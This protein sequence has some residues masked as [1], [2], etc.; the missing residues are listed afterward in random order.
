VQ[1]PQLRT[2]LCYLHSAY[3]GTNKRAKNQN[4]FEFLPFPLSWPVTVGSEHEYIHGS[5]RHKVS[6]N[7]RQTEKKFRILTGKT[8][9]HWKHC[10]HPLEGRLPDFRSDASRLW[11]VGGDS[12]SICQ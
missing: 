10:F 12:Y 9:N 8:S 2:Y 7:R 11:K 6:A 1:L 4:Y 3:K 5:K